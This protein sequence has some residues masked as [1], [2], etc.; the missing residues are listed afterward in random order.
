LAKGAT[1]PAIQ[2]GVAG[3]FL[4]FTISAGDTRLPA[5]NFQTGTTAGTIAIGVELGGATDRKTIAI[6]AAPVTIQS[7]T[8]A[9]SSG[10]I[11]LRV[12]GFDNTRSA[13][14]VVYTFY[15]AAGNAL[16]A[17][18]VD[19]SADFR[20][21]F[22]ESDLGGLFGLRAV[23]PVTGDGSRIT[24]FAVEMRNSAGNAVTGRLPF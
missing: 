16:P 2:L 22:A 10:S 18:T 6:P 5:V 15:D 7:A 8:A 1:D 17:I 14:T 19:N 13:G 3:R 23:F 11:E 20:A 12:T 4:P 21:W 9:R 24:G